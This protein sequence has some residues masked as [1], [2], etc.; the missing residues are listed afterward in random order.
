[1]AAVPA[2][3]FSANLATGKKLASFSPEF[4]GVAG[5]AG[6]FVG[7]DDMP[8]VCRGLSKN[9]AFAGANSTGN[10]DELRS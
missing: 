4:L 6:A 1:M 3:T 2:H 9:E 5:A 10:R 7:R 8:S